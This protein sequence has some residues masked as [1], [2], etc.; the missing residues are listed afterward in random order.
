MGG[1]MAA[2]VYRRLTRRV[3]GTENPLD[4]TAS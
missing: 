1:G 4:S 2:C 3:R